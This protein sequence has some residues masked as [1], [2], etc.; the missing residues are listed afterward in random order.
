MAHN[1]WSKILVQLSQWKLFR[2]LHVCKCEKKPC[3]VTFIINPIGWGCSF[4]QKTTDRPTDRYLL[5]LSRFHDVCY[6]L[7]VIPDTPWLLCDYASDAIGKAVVNYILDYSQKRKCHHFD[8]I[9]ITGC[10]ESCQNDNFQ[11]R[12]WRKF[13]QNDDISVSVFIS[14]PNMTMSE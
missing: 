3:L 6:V 12:Q 4:P 2:H 9:F 7:N 13:R 11:C 8:E 14:V 5:I 10:T 1:I